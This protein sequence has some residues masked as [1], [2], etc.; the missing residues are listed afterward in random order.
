MRTDVTV[1]EDARALVE[2]T[3]REFGRLD[4][5][6]NN[7]GINIAPTAMAEIDDESWDRVFAINVRGVRNCMRAEIAHMLRAGKGAIVNMGSTLGLVGGRQCAAYVAS[8]HA[9]VGLTKAAALDY[10]KA[11]IRINAVCPGPVATRMMSVALKD[12]AKLIEGLRADMPEWALHRG[13]R[14]RAGRRLARIAGRQRP[15]RTLP[16]GRWRLDGGLAMAVHPATAIP[17]TAFARFEREFRG[18]IITPSHAAYADARRVWNGII[19]R[20]PR[21]IVRPSDAADVAAVVRLARE[22]QVP[23]AIRGGGHNVAGSAVCEEGIVCDLSGLRAVHRGRGRSHGA[24]P[25]RGYVGRFRRRDPCHRHGDDRRDGV[26]HRHRWAHA[27]RRSRL[28]DASPR[29]ACGQLVSV[30]LVTADGASVTCSAADNP[31]LFWAVRGGG[32]NFGVV[33]SLTY[34][35]HPVDVVMGGLLIYPLERA[36]DV[37]H[38]YHQYCGDTPDLVT[39]AAAFATAPTGVAAPPRS[40]VGTTDLHDRRVRDPVRPRRS[41]R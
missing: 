7:A 39:T 30:D 29:L 11:G 1:A 14:G 32:G 28:A 26:E 16:S 8:K 4:C 12:D 38:N 2:L 22:G 33:T 36:V 40:V 21:L 18:T 23:F 35:L 41:R 3:V 10:A 31:D 25:G 20:R 37:L 6:V 27:G 5:A 9:V 24:R 15:F 17:S 13:R 34:R 19:D